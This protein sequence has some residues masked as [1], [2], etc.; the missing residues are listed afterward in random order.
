MFAESK[1]IDELHGEK[2]CKVTYVT[3]M[4]IQLRMPSAMTNENFQLLIEAHT[5]QAESFILLVSLTLECQ[6]CIYF[7]FFFLKKIIQL[8]NFLYYYYYDQRT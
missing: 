4:K 3:N 5:T 6:L 2:N 8:S 1:G 7:A